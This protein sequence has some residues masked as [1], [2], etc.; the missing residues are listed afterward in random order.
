MPLRRR[1][2][3]NCGGLL[4]F[5]KKQV[6]SSV[7]IKCSTPSVNSIKHLGAAIHSSPGK[8]S[9]GGNRGRKAGRK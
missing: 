2:E 5:G 3:G 9:N 1:T 4:H 6:T 7:E 8:M